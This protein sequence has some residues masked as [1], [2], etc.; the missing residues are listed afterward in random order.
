[1]KKDAIPGRVIFMK[2]NNK[3]H[4]K[5]CPVKSSHSSIKLTKIKKQL[6]LVVAYQTRHS[7]KYCLE[8]E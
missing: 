8:L 5:S 7:D 3:I 4:K 2:S 6:P 1:L